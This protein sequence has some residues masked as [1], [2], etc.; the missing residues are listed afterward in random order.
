MCAIKTTDLL[1]C[2]HRVMESRYTLWLSL[3]AFMVIRFA[4]NVETLTRGEKDRLTK[5]I[6]QEMTI[7]IRLM[8]HTISGARTPWNETTSPLAAQKCL[9]RRKSPTAPKL[10]DL[11]M[12]TA[13]K[14]RTE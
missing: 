4:K 13:K 11:H 1:S 10:E 3:Q 5:A 9:V 8:Q 6:R 12:S 2:S 7:A 14:A